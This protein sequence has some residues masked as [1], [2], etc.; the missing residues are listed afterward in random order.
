MLTFPKCPSR[1]LKC[2][3]VYFRYLNALTIDSLFSCQRP[4]VLLQPG[5]PFT[6]LL[7]RI[8]FSLDS[9]S[10]SF[11]LYRFI[12]WS[13][14]SSNMLSRKDAWEVTFLSCS[15]SEMSLFSVHPWM[16]IWVGIEL[17]AH[18]F[19][20]TVDSIV[21]GSFSICVEN[22]MLFWFLILFCFCFFS[23][24]ACITFFIPTVLKLH[25][26]CLHVGL[27][28]FIG[29]GTRWK[30]RKENSYYFFD[31][32][33]FTIFPSLCESSLSHTESSGQII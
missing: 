1:F 26:M 31:N 22:L 17:F 11:W 29:L 25:R 10:S 21:F 15:L 2:L 5:P 33:H 18:H 14:C 3:A 16:I 20:S 9:V 4:L 12:C 7:H 23:P 24:E 27:F 19:E 32:S 6:T 30:S 28:A 13:I 8:P